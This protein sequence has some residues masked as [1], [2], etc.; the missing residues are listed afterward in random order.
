MYL[1]DRQLAALRELGITE[2]PADEPAFYAALLRAKRAYEELHPE[3]RRGG[4]YRKKTD[5]APRFAVIAA[6]AFGVTERAMHR[7]FQAAAL[8]EGNPKLASDRFAKRVIRRHK[9]PSAEIPK[10]RKFPEREWPKPL[11]PPTPPSPPAFGKADP[12]RYRAPE[13]MS[14]EEWLRHYERQ[15]EEQL[16]K[17]RYLRKYWYYHDHKK[18]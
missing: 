11:P 4:V 16:R 13:P 7:K 10:V 3:T 9:N 1:T 8:I 18:W 15:R 6:K 17:T 14:R 5:P 2:R 12:R